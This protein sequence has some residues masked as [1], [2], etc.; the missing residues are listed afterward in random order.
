MSRRRLDCQ[1]IDK[2]K[3]ILDKLK[4]EFCQRKCALQEA[5]RE[6]ECR[7]KSLKDELDALEKCYE[8]ER[9]AIKRKFRC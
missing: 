2:E 9:K 3:I 4:E 1:C 8:K 6:C 7:C 5:I